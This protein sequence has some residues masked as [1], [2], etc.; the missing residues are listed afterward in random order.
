MARM[1]CWQMRQAGTD[2]LGVADFGGS[3]SRPP[4]VAKDVLGAVVT[5]AVIGAFVL[6]ATNRVA[7]PCGAK[8]SE[9]AGSGACSGI[10]AIAS[11]AHEI[12]TLSVIACSALAAIAF[13]WYMFWGYKKQG[14]A[15]S[16][17]D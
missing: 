3:R 15:E 5:L 14:Q 11:H 7:G 1:R 8:L 13:V 12:V 10:S 4:H 16:R 9:R 17:N 2:P 6:Q